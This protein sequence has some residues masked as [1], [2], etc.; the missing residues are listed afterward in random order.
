MVFDLDGETFDT[1]LLWKP[2]RYGP[3]L[4]HPVFLQAELEVVCASMVFLDDELRHG[5]EVVVWGVVN[6]WRLAAWAMTYAQCWLSWCS[7]SRKAAWA[8]PLRLLCLDAQC[9]CHRAF[10]A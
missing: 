7:M 2:L 10:V 3:A 6:A 9:R 1:W 8:G 5:E 4:V